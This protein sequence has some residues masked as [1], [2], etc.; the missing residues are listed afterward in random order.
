[1]KVLGSKNRQSRVK[2]KYGSD[3]YETILL[4]PLGLITTLCDARF[5]RFKT[6]CLGATCGQARK[7]NMCMR[8][9]WVVQDKTTGREDHG[10]SVA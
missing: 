6:V 10:Y 4:D 9:Y 8:G 3:P 5:G 2:S 7:N 1:M